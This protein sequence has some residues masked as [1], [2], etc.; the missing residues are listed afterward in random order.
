MEI[1]TEQTPW[2]LNIVIE[3]RFKPMFRS[4]SPGLKEAQAVYKHS[5]Q[6]RGGY[7]EYKDWFSDNRFFSITLRSF[8]VFKERI[9]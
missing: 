4:M 8:D 9:L 1:Q 6:P 2:I 7:L 5:R 3:F